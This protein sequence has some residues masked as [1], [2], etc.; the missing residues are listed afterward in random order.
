MRQFKAGEV[1]LVREK[2]WQFGE[3][4][5]N[6]SKSFWEAS[7]KLKDGRVI[8]RPI[9]ELKSVG[10]PL[11]RDQIR[12]KE[13]TKFNWK[14]FVNSSG[15]ISSA[16]MRFPRAYN[17]ARTS[18]GKLQN[19]VWDAEKMN[20]SLYVP[21]RRQIRCARTDERSAYDRILFEWIFPDFDFD[22]QYHNSLS[23]IF[24]FG[25]ID[26]YLYEERFVG[27]F[28]TVMNALEGLVNQG[29]VKSV[30]F[31]Q[32]NNLRELHLGVIKHDSELM[33]ILQKV[34]IYVEYHVNFS[35]SE[36]PVKIDGGS[37][38]DWEKALEDYAL[39]KDCHKHFEKLTCKN[40]D[41]VTP[42]WCQACLF[43]NALDSNF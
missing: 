26:P 29:I 12:L 14:D 39:C 16:G 43:K 4:V 28:S 5:K 37:L 13:N 30:R 18:T 38:E 35:Y 32:D 23:L 2:Q 27:Y 22:P 25:G 7:V 1:V 11:S 24:E 9:A 10:G 36:N 19:G 17:R 34:K 41:L 8:K 3:V 15:K 6:E 31:P 40:G 21:D 42:D 33:K 20:G